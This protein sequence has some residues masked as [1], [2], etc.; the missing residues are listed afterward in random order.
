MLT[1]ETLAGYKLL[2]ILRDGYNWPDGYPGR[3]H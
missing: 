3:E 1:A 2:I